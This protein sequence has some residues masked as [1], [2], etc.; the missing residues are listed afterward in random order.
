MPTTKQLIEAA[1]PEWPEEVKNLRTDQEKIFVCQYVANGG[2]GADAVRDAYGDYPGKPPYFVS[3]KAYYL[4]GKQAIKEAVLALSARSMRMLAPKAIE[5][6]TDI[7]ESSHHKDRLKAAG[8]VLD[9]TDPTT[10]KVDITH[11]HKIDATKESLAYLRHLKAQG[12]PRDMLIKEFGSL[13][14]EYYEGLLAKED[15]AI[16]GEFVELPAPDIDAPADTS[17][18]QEDAELIQQTVQQVEH[19]EWE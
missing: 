3:Q 7:L 12:A 6:V 4:L 8:M 13:G 10:Q 18:P 17:Q 1:K 5:A 9:R 11:T 2:H 19:E 16:E 15:E 14:L